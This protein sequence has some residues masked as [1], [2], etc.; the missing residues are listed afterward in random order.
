MKQQKLLLFL[1]INYRKCYKNPKIWINIR[2][3]FVYNSYQT[4][5]IDRIEEDLFN[6]WQL[7]E[8]IAFLN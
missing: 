3:F 5:Q 8:D 6:V 7:D 2:S 4:T 1:A